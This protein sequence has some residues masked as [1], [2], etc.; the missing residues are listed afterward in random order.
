MKRSFQYYRWYWQQRLPT[1]LK[2]LG[3]Q[4][5]TIATVTG[6]V[7]IIAVVEIVRR[8]IAKGDWSSSVTIVSIIAIMLIA[9]VL[10]IWEQ[11]RK[12]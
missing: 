2:K 5:A 3:W 4:N 7:T 6:L 9:T 10:A 1:L 8:Y 11:L 12:K